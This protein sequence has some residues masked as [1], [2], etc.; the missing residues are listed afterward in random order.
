MT[1]SFGVD[2]GVIYDYVENAKGNGKS[3]KEVIAEINLSV[4]K[5]L[6]EF[7]TELNGVLSEVYGRID[8]SGNSAIEA[9]TD[10]TWKYT[11]PIR[12]KKMNEGERKKPKCQLVGENGNVF[13]IIGRV[14]ACLKKNGEEALAKEYRGKC[15]AAGSYDE[16]LAITAEYVEII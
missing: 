7:R 12:E 8:V 2:W 5:N 1:I 16:V 10:T 6:A 11:S 13:N 9:N 15:F 4:D 3:E 14:S